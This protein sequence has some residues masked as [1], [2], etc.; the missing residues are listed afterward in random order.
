LLVPSGI[1]LHLSESEEYRHAFMTIHNLSALLLLT[2]IIPHIL[3][4]RGAI[5]TYIF[6]RTPTAFKINKEFMIATTIVTF[7]I[8]LGLLHVFHHG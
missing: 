5:F 2:S 8:A 3:K 6:G 4:Y 7:V 1:A